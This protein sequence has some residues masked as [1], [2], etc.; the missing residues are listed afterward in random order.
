MELLALDGAMI[1]NHSGVLL[2][3]GAIISVEGGSASG[4]REAAALALSDLGI[5][6]KVSADGPITVFKSQ[7]VAIR[8]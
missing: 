5:G 4:G 1:L 2:A 7:R 3:A 8:T 6:I